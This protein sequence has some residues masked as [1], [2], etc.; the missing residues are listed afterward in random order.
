MEFFSSLVQVLML[1]F[2][3]LQKSPD[4]MLVYIKKAALLIKQGR[5]YYFKE[6]LF[7]ERKRFRL[8]S[9]R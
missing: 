3:N 9:Q 5:T 4:F 2:T 8:L 6:N 7:T 1:S